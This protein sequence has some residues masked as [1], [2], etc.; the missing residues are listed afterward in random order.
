MSITTEAT[1]DGDRLTVTIERQV[2]E[3]AEHTTVRAHVSV[4]IPQA[5]DDEPLVEYQQRI[6][7]TVANL[8]LPLKEAVLVELGIPFEYDGDGI[9]REKVPT[10]TQVKVPTAP[11][12]MRVVPSAPATSAVKVM[13]KGADGKYSKI[14]PAAAKPWVDK[15]AI[16]AAEAEGADTLWTGV[17]NGRRWYRFNEKMWNKPDAGAS[18]TPAPGSDEPF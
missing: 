1:V 12:T 17:T 18:A 7:R 13:E 3:Y 6:S 9:I 16:A 2:G 14:D 10:T 15:A 8:S 5:Q 4:S 11:T